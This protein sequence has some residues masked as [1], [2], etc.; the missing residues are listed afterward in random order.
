[1]PVKIACWQRSLCLGAHDQSTVSSNNFIL[2]SAIIN[3][4]YE[5]KKNEGRIAVLPLMMK[6][7]AIF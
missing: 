4:P 7:T 5:V 6:I 3:D 1:M 2:H